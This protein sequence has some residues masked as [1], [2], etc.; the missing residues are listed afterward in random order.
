[1]NV[2]DTERCI[3]YKCMQSVVNFDISKEE[4][5]VGGHTTDI[6]SLTKR[7]Y[8]VYSRTDIKS[9]FLDI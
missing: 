4:L 2:L 8:E 9:K 7:Y 5:R 3:L 1:M 6:S